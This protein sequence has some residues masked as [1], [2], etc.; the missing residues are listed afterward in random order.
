MDKAL[1][2]PKLNV[3]GITF[4]LHCYGCH[5]VTLPSQPWSPL[6]QRNC[7]MNS[8]KSCMI[9]VAWHGW[10]SLK[11]A[12]DRHVWKSGLILMVIL[13]NC[14]DGWMEVEMDRFVFFFKGDVEAIV[15]LPSQ[16]NDLNTWG[17][18]VSGVSFP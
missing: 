17:I 6:S 18:P 11:S 8:T 12:N 16:I 14:L 1:G 3:Y 13:I 2:R 7:D 15:C 10:I 9:Y 5:I 4:R